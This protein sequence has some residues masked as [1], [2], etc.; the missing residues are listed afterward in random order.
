MPWGRAGPSPPSG[1]AAQQ[2]PAG[3]LLLQHS[4]RPGARRWRFYFHGTLGTVS[5]NNSSSLHRAPLH[6]STAKLQS[7]AF[8]NALRRCCPPGLAGADPGSARAAPAPARGGAAC[9]PAGLCSP[10]ASQPDL[11][12]APPRG[13]CHFTDHS[14]TSAPASDLA[15]LQPQHSSPEEATE[16]SRVGLEGI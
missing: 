3:T 4:S 10:T 12:T 14:T 15:L 6:I 11:H 5:R 2:C 1:L 9:S 8:P 7:F 13:H 16:M